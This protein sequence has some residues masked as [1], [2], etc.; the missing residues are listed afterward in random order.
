M[1]LFKDRADYLEAEVVTRRVLACFGIA[2]E[3]IDPYQSAEGG[4]MRGG[5]S[6]T[7]SEGDRLE[8]IEPGFVHY[9]GMG[10]KVHAIDPERSG[11]DFAAFMEHLLR[12]VSTS[13]G[14]P[15]ELLFK[16]FSKTNYSSARAALLEAWR[17]FMRMRKWIVR[18]FCQP[19]WELVLEEAY[20]RRMLYAPNFYE[21]KYEYCNASWIGPGR[22][23]VDPVKEV[24]ASIDSRKNFLTTLA[25]EVAQQGRDWEEVLEQAAR[26]EAKMEE[27]GLTFAESAAPAVAAPIVE[28]PEDAGPEEE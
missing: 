27:L 2:I 19:V 9:L 4:A 21:L 25:D 17:F 16:D 28:E 14:I 6:Q 7:D 8:Q 3:T 12:A 10:E 5:D 23:W 24:T 15:Y 22:G 11:S 1:T 20:L 13:L 18:Y 26:E